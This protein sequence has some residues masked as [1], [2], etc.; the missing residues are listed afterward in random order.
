MP[1][2]VGVR[3]SLADTL[4]RRGNCLLA[5]LLEMVFPPEIKMLPTHYFGVARNGGFQGG[6][7]SPNLAA[8]EGKLTW[9][10]YSASVCEGY[11]SCSVRAS[12]EHTESIARSGVKNFGHV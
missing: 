9:D 12:T 10:T 11:A 8:A 7:T 6:K 3:I 4:R 5:R 1:E 2:E